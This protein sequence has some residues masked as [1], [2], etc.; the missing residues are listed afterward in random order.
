MSIGAACRFAALV[1]RA[2]D[3][4]EVIAV[5]NIQDLKTGT[6]EIEVRMEASTAWLCLGLGSQ[7]YGPSAPSRSRDSTSNICC[8][9][10]AFAGKLKIY[11]KL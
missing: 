9:V 1:G 4:D 5:V 3:D 10:L 7:K 11:R 8:S 2:A 6:Q